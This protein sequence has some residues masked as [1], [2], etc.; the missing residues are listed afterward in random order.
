MPTTTPHP[1][2][3]ENP[4]DAFSV[5]FR[6]EVFTK[7][8]V[9]RYALNPNQPW[10]L[11]TEENWVMDG[12]EWR[13]LG[14]ETA[15]TGSMLPIGVIFRKTDNTKNGCP[16]YISNNNVAN[17]RM[18]VGPIIIPKKLTVSWVSE[19]FYDTDTS[20][21]VIDTTCTGNGLSSYEPLRQTMLN[22]FLDCPAGEF[23]AAAPNGAGNVS[24]IT[25]TM[26]PAP[27]INNKNSGNLKKPFKVSLRGI[28]RQP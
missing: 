4:A 9:N 13:V 14:N 22:E 8:F 6:S 5:S 26:T 15:T 11:F 10:L 24:V 2:P 18:S 16:T 27:P 3:C 17:L 19:L 21:W 23:R 7:Y 25:K 20:K 12:K 28:S 1:C